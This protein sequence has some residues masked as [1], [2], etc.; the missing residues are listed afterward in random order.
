MGRMIKNIIYI[1]FA[2]IFVSAYLRYF[3]HKTLYFPTKEIEF[4]PEDAGLYYEDVYFD[5]NDGVR[6]NGWLIP[7]EGPGFTVLFC[8]GNGGN[9]GHRIDKIE[10]LNRLGVDI[11]IFDYR[12]YGRS[13][14]RPSEKGL[15]RDAEAAYDYLI[16]E[17]NVPAGRIILYG[18]SLGGAVAIELAARENI[19]ALV[20][21]STFSSTEDMAKV[22]YPFFPAFILTSKFNSIERIKNINVPKLIM[23]S[24]GDEIVPFGQSLKLFGLAPQ[25]KKHVILKGSHNTSHYDSRDLYIAGI[26]D[27][28]ESL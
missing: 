16:S 18:E 14:G 17:K 13:N 20:T 28:L 25:P 3:E 5:T 26:R 8:H 6:L 1:S 23:H 10:I 27:F 7:S 4:T 9:I 11:F 19:K 22:L 15:Y 24:R 21:E 12:G 2:V